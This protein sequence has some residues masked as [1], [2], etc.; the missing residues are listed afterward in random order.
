[1][2]RESL[3]DLTTFIAVANSLNFRE[4]ASQFGV[5]AS[6]LSHSMRQLEEGVGTRL[7]NR[8]TRS[9][10]LTDAGVR[11]LERLRPARTPRQS[12]RQQRPA[13]RASCSRWR[14]RWAWASCPGRRSRTAS[15]RE[16]SAATR[17]VRSIPSAPRWVCRAR[18]IMSSL[19]RSA[20]W[21]TRL[22]QQLPR[23]ALAWVRSRPGVPSTLIG[24]RRPDQLQA[25]LAAV[26][27]ILTDAKIAQLNEA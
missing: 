7:L 6:A 13:T 20:P 23:V 24:A 27:L 17:P 26:D 2:R 14:K 1:M 25:N 16:N 18:R 8:T 21:P 12:R 5:A 22:A 4:A 9:V 11:L 3:A 10:S 19:T 15:C